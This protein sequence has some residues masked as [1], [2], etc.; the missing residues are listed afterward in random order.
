MDKAPQNKSTGTWLQSMTRLII[1]GAEVGL[2]K[3][4]NSLESWDQELSGREMPGQEMGGL[5]DKI[6]LAIPSEVVP[7][8]IES[9]ELT[10]NAEASDD[11]EMDAET[12]ESALLSHALIGLFFEVQ[13]G[14]LKG[15]DV[16]D[17]TSRAVSHLS[18]PWLRP[19][20]QSR[21]LRPL[22]RQ[23]D[24]LAE[25]GEAEL[26]RWVERGRQETEHGRKLVNTAISSTV[27]RSI[28]T[29]TTN[30]EVQELVQ[31]QSTGLA[32]EMLE[33]V[34]ERTVSADN[35]L[36]G[37]ARRI[38]R[39]KPREQLPEPPVELIERATSARSQKG[40][41]AL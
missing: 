16:F 14:L 40:K 2:S 25:R 41:R 4:H 30:P 23:V 12:G 22:R 20:Q 29:L 31:K 28:E 5:P 21:L 3:L 10:G 19:L 15:I 37:I 24:R 32:N 33:E 6:Q 17:H 26:M 13:D 27:D 1:G 8:A 36:E 9:V 18:E 11:T 35:F 39:R 7:P 34:R 38:L